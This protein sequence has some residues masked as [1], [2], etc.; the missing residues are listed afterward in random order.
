[1]KL[2]V[3][4]S[5]EL[6]TPFTVI[7]LTLFLAVGISGL[8][9]AAQAEEE[10]RSPERVVTVTDMRGRSVSVPGSVDSLIALEAGS[11]RLVSYLDATD[12]IIAVEDA[13]HG[14]EKSDYGFFSLAT[15]RL[16]RPELRNLPSIGSSENVEGLIA[17]D[18]DLIISSQRDIG[19]LDHLQEVTGI[20]VFAVDVDLE[21]YD[22]DLF[23]RQLDTLGAILD[24]SKRSDE[25]ISGIEEALQDLAIR[26][27]NIS[28]PVKAYAGGMMYYGPADLLR[29]TGDYLPFDLTGT[30]NVMPTNP[31]GNRQPYMTSVEDLIASAPE[32]V[33]IDAANVRLSRSGF[34]DNREVLEDLVPAFRD[35]Q[36]YTTFVYKY[37]GTNWENQLINI[38]AVGKTLYPEV[39]AD[40]TIEEKAEEIWDLFFTSADGADLDHEAVVRAQGAGVQRVDWFE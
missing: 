30:V 10:T 3:L 38:Y 37:Y 18:P 33:F 2:L 28:E 32:Y 20:P 24:R 19:Q 26:A 1:M 11:L 8:S 23:F 25:L 14:R 13:G 34:S 31:T 4:R 40:I 27:E 9:G 15:Y 16:A 7:L 12:K 36:V 22:T 39:F 35:R 5:H 17:A 21:F 6:R 29:T